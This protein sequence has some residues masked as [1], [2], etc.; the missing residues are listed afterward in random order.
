[1]RPQHA[2]LRPGIPGT[3]MGRLSV[4]QPMISDTQSELFELKKAL[5]QE[6]AKN[7]SLSKE[8]K[9]ELQIALSGISEKISNGIDVTNDFQNIIHEIRPNERPVP[10]GAKR[11][12]GKICYLIDTIGEKSL[13][14]HLDDNTFSEDEE[15][16]Q[17]YIEI[18]ERGLIESKSTGK[19]GVKKE[20]E[21][22]V[23]KATISQSNASNGD[24]DNT[25]SPKGILKEVDKKTLLIEFSGEGS[26]HAGNK[27]QASKTYKKT[28]SNK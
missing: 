10:Q 25:Q 8:R 20:G 26:R 21:F 3:P 2:G 13:Y 24:I 23:I 4:I 16:R 12:N 11:I 17:F 5:S 19:P 27:K 9:A 1:M 15:K 14:G 22:Y 7:S 28:F 18:M 6:V